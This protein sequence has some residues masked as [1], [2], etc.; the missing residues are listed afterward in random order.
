[1]TGKCVY[2]SK[3]NCNNCLVPFRNNAPFKD[4]INRLGTPDSINDYYHGNNNVV[5]LEMRAI[6]NQ[7]ASNWGVKLSRLNNIIN[8]SKKT[9]TI[10]KD[11]RV[12]IY[13]CFRQ[14]SSWEILDQENMWYCSNCKDFVEAA[15]RME[16]LRCPPIL[17]IHLKRF[18]IRNEVFT[19]RSGERINTLVG[20]PLRD[21]DLTRF[22]RDAEAKYDLYA[23]SNHYGGTG[24]GH[25]VAF[26]LNGDKWYKY[27]DFTVSEIKESELC[28]P[29]AYVLFYKRKDITPTTTLESLRQRVPETFKISEVEIKS[30][31]NNSHNNAN[32]VKEQQCNLQNKEM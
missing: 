17:I 8:T 3:S 25:Y 10:T 30:K 21:L 14:F 7:S 27:D 16:L 6:F 24:G 15:K 2:C 18:R 19:S 12:T 20:F 22:V 11:N 9:I 5:R 4:I 13:D 1:M 28:T 29:A 26:A 31:P 32:N 23:I